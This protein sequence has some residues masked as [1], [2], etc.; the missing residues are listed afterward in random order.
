MDRS[1]SSC[2]S[3]RPPSY[4][5]N[6][7]VF[8][9]P[10]ISKRLFE[11]PQLIGEKKPA[12]GSIGEAPEV[13]LVAAG[14]RQLLFGNRAALSRRNEKHVPSRS[15][16]VCAAIAGSPKMSLSKKEQLPH[17]WTFY[18]CCL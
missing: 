9:D 2:A 6:V 16:R 15:L 7:G 18:F 14:F 13:P 11:A 8:L 4:L 1:T 5:P 10:V 17:G 12:F 3:A